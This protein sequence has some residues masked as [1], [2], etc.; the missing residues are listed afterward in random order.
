[1]RASTA[2]IS[3]YGQARDGGGGKAA[4]EKKSL[5]VRPR[6][7]QKPP[8]WRACANETLAYKKN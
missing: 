1:M 6:D 3:P 7:P 4:D 2:P 8:S 5:S